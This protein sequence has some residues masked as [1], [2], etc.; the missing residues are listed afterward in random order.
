M[1]QLAHAIGGVRVLRRRRIWFDVHDRGTL[2]QLLLGRSCRADD[3]A[4]ASLRT[5]G[6]CVTVAICAEASS[7]I[8]LLNGV[9]LTR[10]KMG[11]T[12]GGNGQAHCLAF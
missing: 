11:A 10:Q 12:S 9:V 7:S 1:G 5:A 3:Y 4:G 8:N 2:E 6:A